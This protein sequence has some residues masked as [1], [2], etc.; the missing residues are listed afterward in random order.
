MKLQESGCTDSVLKHWGRRDQAKS[1]S[2]ASVI[3]FAPAWP[4]L[5]D[6]FF[7]FWI[8]FRLCIELCIEGRPKS[9]CLVVILCCLSFSAFF[10]ASSLYKSYCNL[11][12]LC[13]PIRSNILRR[14]FDLRIIFFRSSRRI[15]SSAVLLMLALVV[16]TWSYRLPRYRTVVVLSVWS[17]PPRPPLA[18]ADEDCILLFTLMLLAW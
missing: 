14:S 5:R 15:S 18:D 6:T 7:G 10:S 11:S 2:P 9:T 3:T 17:R 8:D 13:L 4:R 1:A 16:C 12:C